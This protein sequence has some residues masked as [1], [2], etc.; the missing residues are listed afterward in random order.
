MQNINRIIK[1]NGLQIGIGVAV[2]VVS[3]FAF[4]FLRRKKRFNQYRRV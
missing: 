2:L 3:F 1:N 4:K